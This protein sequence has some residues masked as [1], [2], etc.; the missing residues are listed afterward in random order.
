MS[1][2]TKIKNFV[3]NKKFLV[4]IGLILL[5]YIAVVFITKT[6]LNSTTNH[7]EKVLVPD[8]TGKNIKNIDA[9][10]SDIGLEYEVVESIYDPTKADGTIISQSPEATKTSSTFVKEGRILR[11]KISKKSQLVEVPNCVDKSQRFAENILKSRGF[12]FKIEYKASTE[13]A[14]AVMQQLYNGKAIDE[15]EKI[16]IGSTI[17]L[18]VGRGGQGEEF[19]TP[20]L[21]D[22]T[23][24]DVKSR[25]S[26]VPNVNLVVICNGCVTAADSCAAIVTSQSP[27]FL[28]GSIMSAGTTL[29]VHATK[30]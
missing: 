20:N 25:L 6:F 11:I 16:A 8:L 1:L 14:G 9:L 30:Q 29:T 13:S 4:N 7:G 22:L 5:T 27:E 28:E 26:V 3:V 2:G 21:L 18:I 10:L 15:K 17:T 23:I 19:P 24:C 12:K